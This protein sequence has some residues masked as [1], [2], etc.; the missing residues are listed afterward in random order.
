MLMESFLLKKEASL[1]L[2][3]DISSTQ[4]TVNRMTA[5]V[6]EIGG[7]FE[8]QSSMNHSTVLRNGRL[9][10]GGNF[11]QGGSEYSFPNPGNLL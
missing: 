7:N 2:N 8:T 11:R 10:I 3:C 4:N 5:G 9:G 1:M 6:I